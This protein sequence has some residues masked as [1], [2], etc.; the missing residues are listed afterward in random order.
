MAEPMLIESRI[1][2]GVWEGV[3]TAGPQG[4][5]PRLEVLLRE[6]S[7]GGATIASLPERPGHWVVRVPI[8]ADQLADGVQ[9]FVLRQVGGEVLGH[10]SVTVG[11]DRG[12]DL[13]AELD[14]LR[15]ELDL[16][17]RAFRRHVAESLPG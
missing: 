3:L 6:R 14:L 8:P 9:T 4:E 16:L 10:F 2:A 12:E 11:V 7:V 15:A 13:R 1:R 17:K 5:A